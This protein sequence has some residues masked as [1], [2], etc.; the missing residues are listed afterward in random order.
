MRVEARAN[1]RRALRQRQQ[2]FRGGQNPVAPERNLRGVARKLL[3]QRD[4]RRVLGVGAADLDDVGELNRLGVKRRA[5]RADGGQQRQMQRARAGQ[6][7]RGGERVV[8]GLAEIDVVV[9]V[10]GAFAAALA[11]QTLVGD[12]GQH[13]VH[14]HVGLRA[15]SGLPDFQRE[16]FGPFAGENLVGGGDNRV[17]EF[18]RQQ[19]EVAVDAGRGF[20]DQNERREQRVGHAP[21]ADLE[22]FERALRLRAPMMFR[23][24]GDVAETVA[25]HSRGH[26]L[27]V[28]RV[29]VRP[30][31]W[32]PVYGSPSSNS[33]NCGASRRGSASPRCRNAFAVSTRPRGVRCRKP[34]CSR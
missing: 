2:G 28:R 1:R 21:L 12:R 24:D 26:E 18:G 14:V 9:G 31:L 19:A 15:R 30:P 16:L 29:S 8:R 13:L 33:P 4:G 34:C 5:Q 23:G 6:V 17:G 10:D 11:G 7:H 22:M 27:S 20:L 25:F 3:A 32:F